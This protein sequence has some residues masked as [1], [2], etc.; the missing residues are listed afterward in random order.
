M[1]PKPRWWVGWNLVP[2]LTG[3]PCCVAEAGLLPP[4]SLPKNLL[5][6]L[7]FP[8]GHCHHCSQAMFTS[9]YPKRF[10]LRDTMLAGVHRR[11]DSLCLGLLCV[12]VM[13]LS[14]SSFVLSEGPL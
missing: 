7:R 10:P 11:S 13:Q 14:S 5:E 6:L 3:V 12:K 1:N 8:L 2:G 4:S 9:V